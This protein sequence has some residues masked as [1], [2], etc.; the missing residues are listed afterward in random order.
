MLIDIESDKI[1]FAKRAGFKYVW[2]SN[3]GDPADWIKDI[4]NGRGADITVEGA[5]ASDTLEQCLKSTRPFGKVVAMGNP[6]GDI[7]LSQ[8]AY[9]ELLR[10]QLQIFGT[11][12]S[13]F[14]PFPKNDWA[15]AIEGMESKKIDVKQYITHRF[16]LNQGPEA[17]AMMKEKSEFY[18]KVMLVME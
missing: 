9:W 14:S 7:K 16:S 11:W 13:S 4:T 10:K 18:N 5:G 1:A 12:N 17:L 6:A 3:D 8:K 15:L 2:N